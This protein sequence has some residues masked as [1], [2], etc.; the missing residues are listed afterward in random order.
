MDPLL[1]LADDRGRQVIR[2]AA[3][4]ASARLIAEATKRA[5]EKRG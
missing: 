2:A 1:H 4:M 3:Y 5:N